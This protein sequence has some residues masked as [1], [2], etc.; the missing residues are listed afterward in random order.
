[1]KAF[2]TCLPGWMERS[3][4]PLLAG[5]SCVVVRRRI[6]AFVRSDHFGQA[7]LDAYLSS[8]TVP[9]SADDFK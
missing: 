9:Y 6:P 8:C 5:D 3:S 4:T 2:C 7:S 1:M